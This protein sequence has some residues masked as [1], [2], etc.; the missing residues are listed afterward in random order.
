MS[1]STRP[2]SPR[3]FAALFLNVQT[4][5][6]GLKGDFGPILT[7]DQIKGI[8]KFTQ[9]PLTDVELDELDRTSSSSSRHLSR[10]IVLNILTLLFEHNRQIKDIRNLT[11]ISH[12]IISSIKHG[13]IWKGTRIKYWQ[14]RKL[15]PPDFN[16][17]NHSD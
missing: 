14:S 4:S 5:T 8:S 3:I 11:G 6:L 17:N 16:S 10:D 1:N 2:L 9:L 12:G 13:R 15:E 7:K